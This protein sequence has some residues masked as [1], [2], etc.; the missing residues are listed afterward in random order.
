MWAGNTS[1]TSIKVTWNILEN[2]FWTG[3]PLG[4]L[5]YYA[6][7][8][9]L[10]DPLKEHEIFVAT[11]L[12]T[13]SWFEIRNLSKYKEYRMWMNA[14]TIKGSGINN[15]AIKMITDESGR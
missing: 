4:Y 8:A 5:L 15:T 9:E 7:E 10:A 2:Q 1:S 6:L 14:F 13:D 12:P 3:I 11:L